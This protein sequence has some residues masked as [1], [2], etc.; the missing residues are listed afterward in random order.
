MSHGER[1][2]FIGPVPETP[3]PSEQPGPWGATR[4][5]G[6][7]ATRIDAYERVSGAAIF[8]SDLVLPDMLHGAILRCPHPHARV[9]SVDSRRAREMPGVAVVLASDRPNA[10]RTG[11]DKFLVEHCRYEGEVV[12]ALAAR[13]PEE[14]QDALRMIEVEYEL[15]PH[16]S[17]ERRAL[18]PGVPQ[19]HSSGNQVAPT[20]L[21]ER[22][23][24]VEGFAMADAVVETRFDTAT[25]IH[26]AIEPHGCVAR[27][28]GPRLTIWEST[29][30]AFSVQAG[31]AGALGLPL[32]SVRVIG[33]YVGGGF[34]AKLEAGKYTLLAALLAREA[35]RPVRLFLTR[36]ETFLAVGNRP[37][38]HMRL[39]AGVRRDGTLTALDFEASGSGG[40]HPA[41]GVAL[42]DWLVRDLYSCPNV[43][44]E[45]TDLFI[46]AGPARPFRGPGHPQGAFALEQVIDQLAEKIGLDPL[47]LRLRNIPEVSQARGGIPYTVSGLRRCLEEGA[48]A[49]G[50]KARRA[51]VAAKGE[52]EEKGASG[53]GGDHGESKD[54]GASGGLGGDHGASED[55][56]VSEGLG[57]DHGASEDRGASGGLGGGESH[58]ESHGQS[59][60]KDEGASLQRGVGL[61]ACLWVAGAGG[62]PSTI[63]LKLFADGS[64]NINF[65]ASDLGTG[66]KT[67]MAL[68]V[69]EELGI[70]P[71]RVQIEHA[72]TGTTQFAT[73]SGGSKTIPTEAPAM[74]DAALAV[75]R[76][77]LEIAAKEVERPAKTLAIEGDAI[78]ARDGSEER[79]PIA[80]LRGLQR[81][82]VLIGVGYRA[83]NPEGK[84]ISPFGAQ[85]CEVE[86]NRLT[87]E[88]RVLRFVGAHDSGRVMNRLSYDNQVRGGI[89]MGIGFG[90]SE[91][92]RLDHGQTGRMLNANLHDYAIPT[93]LDQPEEI[94]SL[95]IDLPDD[96]ANTTGAKGLGEPVT[97]PTAAAIANAVYDALG[98]R[99]TATPM[100]PE[101]IL[102]LLRAKREG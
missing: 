91:E 73:P 70:L 78:I 50:W 45:L 89:V 20:A 35:A 55:R 80:R 39:K 93:A 72:D 96:E 62:P 33:H 41:G 13:T 34:G 12:A 37:P 59:E 42:V 51:A 29:Q 85:F 40:A 101:Q 1:Y 43:R 11:A 76:Q 19:V 48:C 38:N 67:V 102:T 44:T 3:G 30:G 31:V 18:D 17:D 61:A 66:T 83:P 71:E 100:T 86:A 98:V 88:L 94:V 58:D 79:W 4:F 24:I 75:R 46:N 74:R 21:Y 57:G 7:A 26:C 5:V 95:P 22:G 27:W 65:G 99:P 54:R 82:G 2:Y 25:Q 15:L 23:S 77:L 97:I 28:D 9:L 68:I 10:G 64:A 53:P 69:Q 84:A 47:E 56:G 49:F 16:L 6:K 8:P 63:V 36:E 60:S 32:S 14:A 90:L 87:G 92:R 81:R 52:S